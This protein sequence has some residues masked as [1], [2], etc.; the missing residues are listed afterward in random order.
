MCA[1]AARARL[2]APCP[3]QPI[4]VSD[5]SPAPLRVVLPLDQLL[6]AVRAA[7]EP[8]RTA[9]GWDQTQVAQVVADEFGFLGP[10]TEAR[11]VDAGILDD[12]ERHAAAI[13]RGMHGAAPAGD[14]LV[15]GFHPPEGRDLAGAER[16]FQ[17]AS[18]QAER[19]EVRAALK[20]LAP[21]AAQWP[22]VAKYH[23]ALGQA[24]FVTGEL[25]A[26]ED[27]LLRALRLEPRDADA[28]TLLGNLYQKRGRPADAIPLYERSLAVRRNVY[29]LTN[30]GA[31]LAETG[32]VER[33][34]TTFREAVAGDV[35]YPNAWFGLALTITR[36][37]DLSRVREAVDAL[38]RALAAAG[39]RRKAPDVW[40]NAR[41]LLDQLST[42]EAKEEVPAAAA[43][44][45]TALVEHE[46]AA[47]PRDRLPVRLEERPADEIG[48]NMAKLELGWVHHRPYHRLVV[49]TG[50]AA[51][52]PRWSGSGQAAGRVGPEREH[53]ILHELEHLTLATA[54]RDAGTNKWFA[55]TAE[56]RERAVRVTAPDV[57]RA[58]K[59]GYPE[60]AVADM[61]LSAINGLLGQ[62]FNFPLDLWIETRLLERHPEMRELL[63]YSV[64]R[65]LELGAKIAE[66][67]QLK[68]VTPAVV[69]RANTA[70]NGAMALWLE[71]RFP[72]RTELPARYQKASAEAWALAKRLYAAWAADSTAWT[73]GAEYGW[74]D[75]WAAMLGLQGWYTWQDGNPTADDAAT[76]TD[77]E[78]PGTFERGAADESGGQSST[79]E[80]PANASPLSTD[81]TMA[82]TFY[83]LGALEWV[84]R[85]EREDPGT[86]RRIAAQAALRG[87]EGIR[88]HDREA[89]YDLPGYSDQPLSGL[90]FLSV[91]YVLIRATAPAADPGIDLGEAY[92]GAQQLFAA[93][94]GGRDRAGGAGQAPEEF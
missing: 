56:S 38:D 1:P 63:Y 87:S 3:P 66:D 81:E 20:A 39:E 91:L 10:F 49:A 61:I 23:R 68:K 42:I 94:Q 54:A 44:V 17:R 11:I 77:D 78:P 67:A 31:A 90:Q 7:L 46:L 14:V 62:L 12:A 22:E 32:Q 6:P 51:D 69:W 57:K 27:E 79:T 9:G 60:R 93:K 43:L 29:A 76:A 24:Y 13:V 21:L 80:S 58:A 40:D 15:L 48:G 26:A 8:A 28:L 53:L 25:E 92:A 59:L 55:S 72:R 50:H 65:Q 19:G 36:L 18:A 70:M 83:M 2:A 82:A 34:I 74:V 71:E 35:V 75:R 64:R 16:T 37:Q 85:T 86:V 73:P 89:R 30:L 41:A 88:Y 47:G 33:A 84:A 4:I 45:R 52:A 5:V